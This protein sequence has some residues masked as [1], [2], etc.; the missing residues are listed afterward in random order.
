MANYVGRVSIKNSDDAFAP[1][2][3]NNTNNSTVFYV[4][5]TG[6]TIATGYISAPS[7]RTSGSDG[8]LAFPPSAS[9]SIA[10]MSNTG[11]TNAVPF[12]FSANSNSVCKFNSTD[13]FNY[14]YNHNL[15]SPNTVLS[16]ISCNRSGSV[17]SYKNNNFI[18]HNKNIF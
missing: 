5:P 18:L 7:I 16:S 14:T 15:P 9:S 12:N 4:S 3:I 2:T 1:F 10:S 8:I 13:C 11:L 17:L 6:K